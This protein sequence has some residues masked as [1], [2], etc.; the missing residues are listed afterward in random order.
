MSDKR[1]VVVAPVVVTGVSTG[2]GRA[3]AKVLVDAG[4]PVFGSVRSAE[5][6]A[7]FEAQLG[8]LATALRFDVR[9]GDAIA[10]A[11]E[12]VQAAL[13]DR[14]LAG[15]VNNAGIAVP[16][17]LEYLPV[18][19][20][21]DQLEVNVTGVLAVTQAFLPMLKA[22]E[23]APAGRII[24]I[25]S[26]SGATAFPFLGAYAAAKFGLEALSDTMRRELGVYG[27]AVSVVQPGGVATPIWDK[28]NDVDIPMPR[29]NPYLQGL[30]VF[31]DLGQ[32]AGAQGMPP[33]RIGQKV[34]AILTASRPKPRYLVTQGVVTERIMRMLPTRLLDRLIARRLGLTEKR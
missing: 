22:P 30:K 25:S 33:E 23:G 27:I 24:N 12:R 8:S 31:R 4:V 34:L 17:P 32:S 16:G 28:S 2:I 19:Q 6:A 18:D 7:A 13:G 29:R 3:I 14:Q 9:D 10:A 5:D 26:V 21:R 1:P 20:F 15:L 11:A